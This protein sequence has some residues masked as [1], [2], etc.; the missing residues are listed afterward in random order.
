VSSHNV[1]DS[2]FFTVHVRSMLIQASSATRCV[3]N[4]QQC[5]L[6]TAVGL[7]R[8]QAPGTVFAY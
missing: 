4:K 7:G 5:R 2:H 8:S 6:T 3:V 1:F